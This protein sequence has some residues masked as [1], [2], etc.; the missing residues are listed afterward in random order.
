MNFLKL[1]VGSKYIIRPL[2]D[3]MGRLGNLNFLP[4]GEYTI[5]EEPRRGAFRVEERPGTWCRSYY[6]FTPLVEVTCTPVRCTNEGLCTMII[7]DVYYIT[8]KLP[9]EYA[10]LTL[11]V[12]VEK[13][14][15][16]FYRLHDLKMKAYSGLREPIKSFSLQDDAYER[17]NYGNY[18]PME[19]YNFS[20]VE[21]M[22]GSEV[23]Y[24]LLQ[25]SEEYY[26]VPRKAGCQLER[27][28]YIVTGRLSPFEPGGPNRFKVEGSART[29]GAN[30]YKFYK[31]RKEGTIVDEKET[32]KEQVFQVVVV[33]DS[34]IIFQGMVLGTSQSAVRDKAILDNSEKLKQ[35][36]EYK[37]LTK[38]F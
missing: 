36:K 29:Y 23:P 35:A 10:L 17:Y 5:S 11:P 3:E 9:E 14:K 28:V 27:G 12:G 16:G 38:P 24:M 13:L 1:N 4:E 26:I 37:V 33:A 15:P 21:D 20:R 8:P 19:M 22:L 30:V 34:Q 6:T 32:P 7:G 25:S 31:L 2:R 18:Y